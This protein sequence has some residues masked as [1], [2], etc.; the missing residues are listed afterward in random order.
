[1]IFTD[2]IPKWEAF[3]EWTPERLLA[4]YGE[5]T[6]NVSA[7]VRMKMKDFFSYESKA[8]EERP[9]YLFDKDFAKTCPDMK[10]QYSM[11]PYFAE[12]LMVLCFPCLFF[13]VM[14]S[15]IAALAPCL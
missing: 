3:R 9:L 12:D 4:K 15:F 5:E 11:P 14:P 8:R 2:I 1:M 10:D 6:F 13:P 7:T